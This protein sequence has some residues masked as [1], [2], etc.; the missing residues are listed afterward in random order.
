MERRASVA[1]KRSSCQPIASSTNKKQNNQGRWWHIIFSRD[2]T[3]HIHIPLF[4]ILWN[5]AP[6]QF[7]CSEHSWLG[8]LIKMRVYMMPQLNI[9]CMSRYTIGDNSKYEAQHN[10][11]DGGALAFSSAPWLFTIYVSCIFNASGVKTGVLHSNRMKSMCSSYCAVTI[12][13]WSIYVNHMPKIP[14]WT[15]YHWSSIWHCF[16]AP[17]NY[18]LCIFDMGVSSKHHILPS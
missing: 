13:T 5:H 15:S 3:F 1:W 7:S 17:L 10:Q 18:G 11:I 16:W 4:L 6:S 9:C 8:Y 2:S 12:G 14:N